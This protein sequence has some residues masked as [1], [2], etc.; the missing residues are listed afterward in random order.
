M[1]TNIVQLFQ[2]KGAEPMWKPLYNLGAKANYGDFFDWQELSRA[3]GFDVMQGRTNI[4]LANKRLLKDYNKVF[5][6][7]RG[8]GYKIGK[9]SEQ[10]T[11]AGERKRRAVRQL[12]WGR[13]ES[14]YVDISQLSSEERLRATHM[15][16]HFNSGLSVMRKRNI[17]SIQKTKES[18]NEQKRIGEQID[19]MMAELGKLK[20]E[21]R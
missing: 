18:L 3:I 11:H 16:N 17:A 5:L 15:L 14:E 1:Q 19:T 9:P 2:P 4:Y 20:M 8:E 6:S 13:L 21:I 7:V 12:N 10:L